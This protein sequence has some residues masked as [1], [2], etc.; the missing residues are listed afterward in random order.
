MLSDKVLVDM[1]RESR[2]V[3]SEISTQLIYPLSLVA[4]L[5]LIFFFYK[6]PILLKPS[7]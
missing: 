3:D 6:P 1:R 5:I 7:L 2:T 4:N